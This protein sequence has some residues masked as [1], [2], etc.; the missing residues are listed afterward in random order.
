MS[1]VFFL[2]WAT[3]AVS[4]FNTI[5]LLWLGLTVLLN[6]ERR[7]AGIWLAG[8]GLLTGTAFFLAHTIILGIGLDLFSPEMDFWW[9]L[10]WIP[11]II[12][13]LAWYVVML[14]Y[15]GFWEGP[16]NPVRHRHRF[17]LALLVTLGAGMLAL[18]IFAQPLPSL[19]Q[20]SLLDLRAQPSVMG[21]S[22]LLIFYPLFILA[23]IGSS[24]EA[25]LHPGP[26]LRMMGQLARLRARPWLVG[27]SLALLLAALLVAAFVSR[28]FSITSLGSFNPDLAR[29]V[30]W[31][32]LWIAA[33]ISTSIL[34]TGQAIVAY[35]V[36]TGKALPRRG[37]QRYWRRVVILAGGYSITVS[38]SLSL[39]L[40]PIYSLLLSTLLMVLFYALLSWRSYSERER[41]ITLLRPFVASQQVYPQ[42][43]ASSQDGDSL[44]TH[45]SF[46]ALCG[47]V[48]GAGQAYLL[49]YGPMAPLFGSPFAYP[50][51]S[52]IPVTPV[53]P[54]IQQNA[55]P[56]TLYLPLD[57]DASGG[58][59]WVVPLWNTRGLC[60]AL[61]LGDKLDG[62]L[63]T[64][65]EIEV[66][67]TAAERLMDLH[68]GVEMA[69]RLMALQRRGMAESQVLDRHTRRVLHDDV[70]PQLHTAILSLNNDQQ[71][72]NL[73]ASQ[74]LDMLEQLH[75]QIA[76]LLHDL[77]AATSPE[78]I[79]LGLV[80]ALEQ[81]LEG[82]LKGAFDQVTWEV[83]E[84]AA[85]RVELVSP[86]AGEVLFYAARE[87]MRNAARHARPTGGNLS[88]ELFLKIHWQDGLKIFIQDNGVGMESASRSKDGSGGG[89]AL[90]STL[91]AVFGGSLSIESVPG[92]STCIC[93]SLPE[94][95]KY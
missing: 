95:D 70:L 12:A 76:D 88:L 50:E 67:R 92:A 39:G 36:F 15:A 19:G 45:W 68:A 47:D 9:R 25:L 5:L 93:L 33:L 11:V 66:A 24:V 79:R 82:E 31:A 63:Y 28:A 52:A 61:L 84:R 14:W 59:T 65:E 90:H 22:V 73:D 62:G 7:T 20:L 83:D 4:S 54:I 57:P 49:P 87:A 43:L 91:L 32:D 21:I 72:N 46:Q 1:G 41:I 34:M 55:T 58:M 56:Q 2:D 64:Q 78:V 81:V 38:F 3:Q 71:K 23:C 75:R 10:G 86:L 13:P 51:G 53:F 26:T 80:G 74:T 30:A 17:W 6:A 16:D 48:L 94:A 40:H 37:L 44:D 35:E 18:F 77:P 27:S 60:G 69:R 42:L 8:G 89:L 29:S 85:K